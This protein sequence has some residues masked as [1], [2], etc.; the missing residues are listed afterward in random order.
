[1]Q[2]RPRTLFEKIRGKTHSN[3]V[4]TFEQP[5]LCRFSALFSPGPGG[6]YLI[7]QYLAPHPEFD[8]ALAVGVGVLSGLYPAWRSSRLTP[9]RA[10]RSVSVGRRSPAR[11]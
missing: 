2:Q 9:S 1:M 10:T 7:P 11:I 4:Y 3:G 5:L 8:W 6:T